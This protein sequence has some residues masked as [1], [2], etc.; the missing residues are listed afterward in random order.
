[1]VDLDRKD[2]I[3]GPR[4]QGHVPWWEV[5]GIEEILEGCRPTR[6]WGGSKEEFIEMIGK[7]RGWSLSRE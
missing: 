5:Q 4:L 3:T 2:P 6:E 1:M 7:A